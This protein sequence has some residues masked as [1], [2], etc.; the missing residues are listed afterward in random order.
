MSGEKHAHEPA[1]CT[2]ELAGVKATLKEGATP[3]QVEESKAWIA[4]AD[5]YFAHFVAPIVEQRDGKPDTLGELCFHCGEY[6]TGMGAAL[7]GSGGFRWGL[8]HGEG[9]C[10][11]GW[12]ARAHHF[13][14][15]DDGSELFT[16]RGRV[17]SYH[18]DFVT[19]RD[20]GAAA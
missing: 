1:Y 6:L 2:L 14:K 15:R 4:E 19:K 12:P 13:A 3:E 8:A 9:A 20:E 18:P 11:C 17:L 16:L 7:L 10:A 5:A